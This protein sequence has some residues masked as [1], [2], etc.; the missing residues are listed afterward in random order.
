MGKGLAVACRAAERTA[1]KADNAVNLCGS[2][3][4]ECGEGAVEASQGLVDLGVGVSEAEE[5]IMVGMQINAC[6][7]GGGA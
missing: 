3:R 4:G 2:G 7:G 5:P 1:R 6:A